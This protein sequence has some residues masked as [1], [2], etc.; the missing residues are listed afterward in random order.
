MIKAF[1]DFWRPE[2]EEYKN[3][4]LLGIEDILERKAFLLAQYGYGLFG[5]FIGVTIDRVMAQ[6]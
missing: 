3:G 5:K 6:I 4:I 1:D 2:C